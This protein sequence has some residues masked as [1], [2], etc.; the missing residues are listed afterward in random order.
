MPVGRFGRVCRRL[1][2]RDRGGRIGMATFPAV[3]RV[4]GRGSSCRA[5]LCTGFYY[6]C[7][8]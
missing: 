1:F 7:S 4:G 8:G 6:S 5:G 3:G 2:G